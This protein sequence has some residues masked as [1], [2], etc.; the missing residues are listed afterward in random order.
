LEKR[1]KWNAV[2]LENKTRILRDQIRIDQSNLPSDHL[3]DF[4]KLQ[5][6]LE[7]LNF[8]LNQMKAIQQNLI[9][10]LEENLRTSFPTPELILFALT[11]P[12]MVFTMKCY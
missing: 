6:F 4:K 12:S 9:P 5:R 2:G 10:Y 1:L 3:R 11:R 7:E 8:L